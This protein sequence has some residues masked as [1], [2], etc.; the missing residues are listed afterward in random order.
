MLENIPTLTRVDSQTL[1]VLNFPLFI[2]NNS[3]LYLKIH[4]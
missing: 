4:M 2:D 1:H 3:K